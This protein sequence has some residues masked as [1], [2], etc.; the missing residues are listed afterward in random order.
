M[1]SSITLPKLKPPRTS[2]STSPILPRNSLWPPVKR[3][4]SSSGVPSATSFIRRMAA[5]RFWLRV[6]MPWTPYRFMKAPSMG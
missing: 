2:R 4:N 3:K 5:P 1:P 6:T